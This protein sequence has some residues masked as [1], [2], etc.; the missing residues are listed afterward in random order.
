LSAKAARRA[1]K[2]ANRAAGVDAAYRE[3]AER[4]PERIVLLD[5]GLPKPELAERVRAAI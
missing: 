3:L 4:F 5:G 1:R 2:R